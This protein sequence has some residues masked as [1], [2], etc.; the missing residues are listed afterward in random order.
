[1]TIP[2]YWSGATPDADLAY[3]PW[4]E[5]GPNREGKLLRFRQLA[6]GARVRADLIAAGLFDEKTFLP[7]AVMHDAPPGA[8]LDRNAVPIPPM[9]SASELAALRKRERDL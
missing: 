9:Y 4:G 7:V 5:D 1:M 6:V 2:R 3:L 8:V